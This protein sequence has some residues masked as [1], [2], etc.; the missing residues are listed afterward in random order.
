MTQKANI[1]FLHGQ[2]DNAHIELQ[3]HLC[4]LVEPLNFNL[5]DCSDCYTVPNNA[6]FLAHKISQSQIV[7][8]IIS[9]HSLTE[10]NQLELRTVKEN[11]YKSADNNILKLIAVVIDDAKTEHLPEFNGRQIV[12]KQESS[13]TEIADVIINIRKQLVNK[14]SFEQ[15]LNDGLLHLNY[16]KQKEEFDTHFKGYYP[17]FHELNVILLRGT[18]EC[19][20][21]L[22]I[23]QFIY[24]ND[25]ICDD[26]YFLNA[27]FFANNKKIEDWI[28][29]ELALR[30][31]MKEA[32][33]VQ[34]EE[35]AFYIA[36]RL[37]QKNI[38]IR[39]DDIHEAKT[40]SL[41]IV[42]WVWKRLFDYFRT[43]KISF[44]Y[45][46][47]LFLTD[48]SGSNAIYTKDQFQ[49]E[50][51]ADICNKLVCILTEIDYIDT[52]SAKNWVDVMKTLPEFKKTIGQHLDHSSIVTVDQPKIRVHQA[53]GKIIDELSGKDPDLKM[54]KDKFLA[55]I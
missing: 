49:G 30:L 4:Y 24:S 47:F 8:F 50:A 46:I 51:T 31:G 22:L 20:I 37:S 9:K 14:Y 6:T 48:Q 12:K 43:T 41:K 39:F 5:S 11:L 26:V 3:E 35:F 23:R 42:Q 29:K 55:R 13:Y 44:K 16:I 32:Y 38:L 25:I 40:E 53:V 45:S 7:V 52:E 18:K 2:K 19:G 1:L 33:T 54:K 10:F 15:A 21:K 36:Q 17:N 27:S 34:F 28:W